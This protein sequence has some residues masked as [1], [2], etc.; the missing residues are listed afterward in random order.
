M[1][2]MLPAPGRRVKAAE[3]ENKENAGGD[4]CDAKKHDTSAL[5]APLRSAR[6]AA[7]KPAEPA[8]A[9]KKPAVPK[10]GAAAKP[11]AAPARPASAP[12][13]KPARAGWDTKGQLDDLRSEFDELRRVV[14]QMGTEKAVL[15]ATVQQKE[16]ALE[17]TERQHAATVEER[18]AAGLSELRRRLAEVEAERETLSVARARLTGELTAARAHAA[19]LDAKIAERDVEIGTLQ[20]RLAEAGARLAEREAE[21]DGARA[22][23]ARLA[24]ELEAARRRV[25]ELEQ[26]ARSDEEL[27]KRLHNAIQELKGNIRVYCRVRPLLPSESSSQAPEGERVLEF[28]AGNG[29]RGIEVTVPQQAGRSGTTVDGRPGEAK[30]H[31]FTFDKVFQPGAGQGEVFSEISQL[32]QSALDGYRVCIFAYGQ[33]GSGK[34]FTMEGPEDVDLDGSNAGMIP[35][36]VEQIFAAVEAAGRQGWSYKVQASFVEIYNEALRDLLATDDRER[37]LEVKHDGRGNTTVADLTVVDV[38]GAKQVYALIRRARK[39]RATAATA[40]NERS[41]RSHSVFRLEIKGSSAETGQGVSGVL[42][43]VDLAGSERLKESGSGNDKERLRETQAI[44]KSLSSLG[45]VICALANKEAH[46]PYRNSKL[47][48]LLQPCL[49]GEAK[50]LMFVNVSPLAESAG[51]SL[52]SLR[53]AQ[54]VN[55]CE[56]GVARASKKVD[57][58]A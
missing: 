7:A 18:I 23:G 19:A 34:T 48:Y 54:K 51:E 52:C 12:A 56:I 25:E 30:A 4:A 22:E 32:V 37:R 43:L 42:N 53:F 46:V 40:M 9:V 39:N 49:G 38:T 50:T 1:K 55:A 15:T 26:Q 20:G 3:A 14:Q 21:R 44:N 10:F 29:Q 11:A 45:D 17:E 36:A 24:S 16:A 58:K 31:R 41:S 8:V 27:R 2:S 47:T 33:T 35:R 28:P 13:K 6:Q 57:L 5:S